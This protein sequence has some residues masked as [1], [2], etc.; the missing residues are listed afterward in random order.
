MEKNNEIKERVDID[1][2]FR[3]LSNDSQQKLIY[4]LIWKKLVHGFIERKTDSFANGIFDATIPSKED[5]DRFRTKLVDNSYKA[6]EPMLNTIFGDDEELKFRI[7]QK[8]IDSYNDLE[9]KTRKE[10]CGY[11][12]TFTEWEE[13]VGDVPQYD[14]DGYI[15]GY[16]SDKKYLKRTCTYCGEVQKAY[17]KYH[18]KKIEDDTEYWANRFPKK[19][20]YAKQR[21]LIRTQNKEQL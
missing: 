13:T 21:N 7:F 4:T 15:E 1:Y 3:E 5:V 20:S 19:A 12:H 11:N 17:S 8:F 14:E 16:I 2:K 6:L 9:R 10:I 18:K